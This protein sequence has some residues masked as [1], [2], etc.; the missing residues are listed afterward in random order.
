MAYIKTYPKFH[1]ISPQNYSMGKSKENI[2]TIL[3]DCYFSHM[4]F[5]IFLR[6]SILYP[7]VVWSIYNLPTHDFK[8]DTLPT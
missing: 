7:P 4:A 1:I 5:I 8:I 3:I 2:R 6:K